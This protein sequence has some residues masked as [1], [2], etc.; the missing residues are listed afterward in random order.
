MHFMREKNKHLNL[1]H[2]LK[3]KEMLDSGRSISNIASVLGCH[4]ATIY[5]ELEKGNWKGDYNP[6]HA[7]SRYEL[8][9]K[10]KGRSDKLSDM[11][12]ARYIS[13]LILK[14]HLS[15]EKIIALLADDNR[16]F[17]GV[18]RSSKT[19][20]SAI[21]KG[22]IPNVTRE[23]LLRKYSTV[24]NDG[25]IC[26]PQWVLEKLGIKDGDVLLLEVTEANEIVYRK[27]HLEQN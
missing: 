11:S 16:G 13:D 21:D 10:K 15:P 19:I 20:Y 6:Y 3:I 8:N 7:Q 26:I 18:P 25:Q 24:F 14:E 9:A 23:S 2:R 27:K 17:S 5:K 4:R 1:E 12:L 22:L